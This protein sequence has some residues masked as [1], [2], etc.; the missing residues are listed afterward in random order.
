MANL[1]KAS[2]AIFPNDDLL[3]A[4]LDEAGLPHVDTTAN[5][6]IADHIKAAMAAAAAATPQQAAWV[7]GPTTNETSADLAGGTVTAA[8]PG[9]R[10]AAPPPA[11]AKPTTQPAP[12]KKPPAKKKI[13]ARTKTRRA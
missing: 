8:E 12:A 2:A 10:A 13:P 4:I 1:V 3:N 9:A 5:N 11:L 7:E 6:E